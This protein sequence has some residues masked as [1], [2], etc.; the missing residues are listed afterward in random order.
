MGAFVLV[1]DD[2]LQAVHDLTFNMYY[3]YKPKWGAS[4]NWVPIYVIGWKTEGT[5]AGSTIHETV[6]FDP[7]ENDTKWKWYSDSFHIN[8]PG[9]SK[10]PVGARTT[11][12]PEWNI[13]ISEAEF[14][15]VK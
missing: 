8:N 15:E 10:D 6:P 12:H 9:C 2:R 1:D 3:L 11:V 4:P 5:A 7:G 13:N 14:V